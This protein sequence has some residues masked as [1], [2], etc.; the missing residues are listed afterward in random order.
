M[1][2]HKS[3]KALYKQLLE[4]IGPQASEINPDKNIHWELMKQMGAVDF[5][6]QPCLDSRLLYHGHQRGMD[7]SNGEMRVLLRIHKDGAS[8]KLDLIP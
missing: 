2:C 4:F 3:P 7:G 1:S 5:P 6:R 8:A